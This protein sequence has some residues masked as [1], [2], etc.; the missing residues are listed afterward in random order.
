MFEPERPEW[1]TVVSDNSETW[2]NLAVGR[3][4]AGVDEWR[5][6]QRFMLGKGKLDSFDGVVLIGGR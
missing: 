5:S 1:A 6:G 2:L 3:D 4:V